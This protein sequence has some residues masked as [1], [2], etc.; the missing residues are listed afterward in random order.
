MLQLELDE[1]SIEINPYIKFLYSE[2]NNES[3]NDIPVDL[4]LKE[5]LNWVIQR[6]QNLSLETGFSHEIYIG[7]FH[8]HRFHIF[9]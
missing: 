6:F 7:N 2:L 9:R 8:Y 4:N 1:E 5:K 3:L